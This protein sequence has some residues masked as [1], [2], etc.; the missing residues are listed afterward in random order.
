MAYA[1]PEA[2]ISFSVHQAKVA[3]IVHC[4]ESHILIETKEKGHRTI[5]LYIL[6]PSLRIN[7]TNEPICSEH[8][9]CPPLSLLT[10]RMT[11]F[12]I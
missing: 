1:E 12:Q 3:K 11:L 9:S 2:I 10:C 8:T 7:G 5:G 6:T 4:G